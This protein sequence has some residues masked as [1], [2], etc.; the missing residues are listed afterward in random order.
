MLRVLDF[1]HNWQK[2]SDPFKH[3]ESIANH[4]PIRVSIDRLVVYAVSILLFD[5]LQG[6]ERCHCDGKH[7]QDDG[8]NEALCEVRK[9]TDPHDWTVNN[10]DEDAIDPERRGF[11]FATIP[12]MDGGL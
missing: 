11:S 7:H 6:E 9:I 12:C 1:S 5:L 2:S 10:H 4:V 8:Q 3:I